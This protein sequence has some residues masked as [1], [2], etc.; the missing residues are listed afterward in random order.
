M[1]VNFDFLLSSLQLIGSNFQTQTVVDTLTSTVT[2]T[3]TLLQTLT[4]TNTATQTVVETSAVAVDPLAQCLGQCQ[5]NWGLNNYK[6]YASPSPSWSWSTTTTSASYAYQTQSPGYYSSMSAYSQSP[7]SSSV[8]VSPPVA[9]GA[10]LDLATPSD[11]SG[12]GE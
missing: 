11:C 6:S 4:Q 8:S 2:D 3:N 7:D 9:S 1:S 12:C 10:P 5:N